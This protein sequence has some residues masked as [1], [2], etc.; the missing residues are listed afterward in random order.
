LK[1]W[2]VTLAALFLCR[3]QK[4]QRTEPRLAATLDERRLMND[5]T[6]IH[7]WVRFDD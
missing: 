3:S 2:A 6:D 1:N 5:E 4:P 7:S